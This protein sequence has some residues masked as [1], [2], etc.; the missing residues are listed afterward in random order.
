MRLPFC[1]TATAF[2]R[3]QPTTHRSLCQRVYTTITCTFKMRPIRMEEAPKE[4]PQGYGLE[5][6]DTLGY[7]GAV[8]SEP[9]INSSWVYGFST[10]TERWVTDL[11]CREKDLL[12][13]IYRHRNCSRPVSERHRA[14]VNS[15][16]CEPHPEQVRPTVLA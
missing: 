7:N 4:S 8:P 15:C 10:R 2:Y 5:L 13:V 14:V 16:D 9:C 3:K 6:P 12:A 11:L 1:Q